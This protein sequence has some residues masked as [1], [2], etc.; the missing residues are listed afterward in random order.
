MTH[1]KSLE[2]DFQ[3]KKGNDLTCWDHRIDYRLPQLCVTFYNPVVISFR[4]HWHEVAF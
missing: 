3:P 2:D 4:Y 1:V